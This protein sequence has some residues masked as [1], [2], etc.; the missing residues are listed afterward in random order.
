MELLA[1]GKQR[2]THQISAEVSTLYGYSHD[3]VRSALSQFAFLRTIERRRVG[4]VWSY[5][6]IDIYERE[7]H[8]SGA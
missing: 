7:H 1:D 2:T 3:A 5:R 6:R 8:A 4:R